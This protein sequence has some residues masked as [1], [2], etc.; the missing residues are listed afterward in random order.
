MTEP[1]TKR[2]GGCFLMAAILIG[3]VVG[4]ATG[5]PLRGVWLGLA[6]GIVIAVGLWLADRRRG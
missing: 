3:F 4:M 5:N 2:A 1:T 6:A